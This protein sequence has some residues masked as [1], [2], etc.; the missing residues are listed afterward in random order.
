MARPSPSSSNG[1]SARCSWLIRPQGMARRAIRSTATSMA[2]RPTSTRRVSPLTAT[3]PRRT[4]RPPGAPSSH[5]S[6]SGWFEA[7]P[8]ERERGL[9]CQQRDDDR[10]GQRPA[11]RAGGEHDA[12]LEGENAHRAGDAV[13][14]GARE[15]A[16]RAHGAA[17]DERVCQR[18]GERD[19]RCGKRGA[20]ERQPH[21]RGVELQEAGG[22]CR[23]A[24]QDAVGAAQ[25]A[26]RGEVGGA[27]RDSMHRNGR[28]VHPEHPRWRLRSIPEAGHP[29]RPALAA[30]SGSFRM[31]AAGRR[32]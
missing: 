17:A 11:E 12:E 9:D 21:D 8:A 18:V 23:N 6:R 27:H 20:D 1:Q 4:E 14:V 30:V 19:R 31:A 32:T 3:R 15:P 13:A 7:A 29:R 26:C 5:P 16:P 25:I 2:A 28:R 22:A 24:Q 10:I